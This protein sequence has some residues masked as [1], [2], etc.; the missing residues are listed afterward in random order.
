MLPRRS[1][2][3]ALAVLAAAC[4]TGASGAP[5]STSPDGVAGAAGYG[6]AGASSAGGAASSLGGT[7][8]GGGAANAGTGNGGFSGFPTGSSGKGGAASGGEL[9]CFDGKDDD[10]N[11]L[12]DCAD[13]TCAS[14]A[15]CAPPAA[16]GWDAYFLVRTG[17]Y[18]AGAVAMAC[19]GG[20][21]PQRLVGSSGAASE[22]L[23]EPA[24]CGACACGGA[25]TVTCD[26]P[27]LLCAFAGGCTG[28]LVDWTDKYKLP[29]TGCTESPMTGATPQNPFYCTV[30]DRVKTG[31]TCPATGGGVLPKVPWTL[32]HDLCPV[33]TTGA[34]CAAG[35][36]CEPSAAADQFLCLRRD[37]V[38]AC[39]SGWPIRYV[40]YQGADDA[41][42]CS[43]CGCVVPADA[44]AG[45][46]WNFHDPPMCQGDASNT[47]YLTQFAGCTNLSGI[48]DS[49][50]SIVLAKPSTALKG[51]DVAAASGQPSGALHKQGQAT[52][53]CK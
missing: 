28:T 36:S 25:S 24:Q 45:G 26:L 50:G 16:A 52:L 43:A 4:A 34:G 47:A 5:E 6:A 46:Q 14:V 40:T 31:A 22:L 13:P 3:V 23:D 10:A 44:C 8:G 29:S 49:D 18:V 7:T 41:R 32:Q 30:H 12:T 48:N 9:Q 20:A 38:Q 1:F 42:A 35:T 11:G 19:A 53:C 2:L 51:C 39:P 15:H 33:A 27:S 17:T 37:G 21:P